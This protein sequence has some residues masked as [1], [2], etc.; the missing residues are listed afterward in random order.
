MKVL[1]TGADGLSREE[2][3]RGAPAQ[4]GCRGPL[5]RPARDR[6][7]SRPVR[8][9]G[10]RQPT[11]S[12]GV[13]RPVRE[14][15]FAEGNAH[16]TE[17]LVDLLA[18]TEAASRSSSRPPPRRARQPLRAEQAGRGAAVRRYGADGRTGHRVPPS[19]ALREVVPTELQLG[20]IDLLPQ[21]RARPCPSHPRPAHEIELAY[22]D[23]VVAEFLKALDGE[24]PASP[25][26]GRADLPVDARGAR[27]PNR[28]DPR[29]AGD[30]AT[31]RPLRPAD[32]RLYATFLSYLPT[33]RICLSAREAHRRTRQPRGTPQVAPV[34]PDLRLA[35][36]S[37][38]SSAGI[39]TTTPRSR[40]SASSRAGRRSASVTSSAAR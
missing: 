18:G 37:R 26:P 17:G 7:R 24:A 35:I 33:D 30:A 25:P 1:V 27:P 3:G 31:S 9:R 19:R 34:R 16:L 13:N 11:T 12:P 22:V 15:E 2:P 8:G 40:N 29:R 5:L 38:A 20:G 39:T 28:G 36:Q 32:P 23:D 21:R 14:E 10:R 4:A 6:D